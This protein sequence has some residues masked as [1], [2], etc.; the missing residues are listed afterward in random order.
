[1]PTIVVEV[2]CTAPQSDWRDIACLVRAFLRDMFA[3][4]R[5][6][7]ILPGQRLPL[8][9]A[10]PLLQR[11]VTQMRVCDMYLPPPQHS[12]LPDDIVPVLYTLHGEAAVDDIDSPREASSEDDEHLPSSTMLTLPH[13]S[14]DGLWE[15]LSYGETPQDSVDLKTDLLTFVHTALVFSRAGVDPHQI[16][17]N[18]LLLFHGPPGT[19]KTSLSR[20]LAHKLAV[21]MGPDFPGGARLIEINAHSLFSRWFSES[22]KQVMQLF[23]RI[24][25]LAA[26]PNCLVCV[27]MDEVESL[28]AARQ[29]AMKGNEP[30]DSIRVVNA[31][32]TQLD[33]LQRM[34][35]VLVLATSN[36][37]G[38]MDVAFLDR[39][40]KRVYIG[41]PGRESRREMLRSSL[42]ELVE[43]GLVGLSPEAPLPCRNG[44]H[45][46]QV[47]A[48][49]LDDADHQISGLS[50]ENGDGRTVPHPHPR[51]QRATIYPAGI[52]NQIELAIDE[53]ADECSGFNGRLLRKLPFLAYGACHNTLNGSGS[54]HAYS[55]HG[56]KHKTYADNE[57]VLPDPIPVGTYLHHLREAATRERGN[58]CDGGGRRPREGEAMSG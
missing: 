51:Q 35:N 28:A 19:G 52:C 53:I 9:S 25:R 5:T 54:C 7:R 21:R 14:L 22:G 45:S 38:A 12:E 56:Q 44:L 49:P 26:D 36:L 30:S 24:R 58:S 46:F 31:L 10:Q 43:R 8:S 18:R 39:A 3:R 33:S 40:D 2:A 50:V 42:L 27:L 48:S 34:R 6:L 17:W 55:S 1:M 29:S 16:I 11:A 57:V 13:T 15:S 23:R 41:P 32:L 20:A 37:T 4:D 47:M